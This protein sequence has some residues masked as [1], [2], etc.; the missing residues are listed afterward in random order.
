MKNGK[1]LLVKCPEG[2]PGKWYRGKYA[3][4]H[5]VEFWRREGRLPM[6]GYVVHHKNENP[7]DNSWDNLEEMLRATHTAQHQQE[8]PIRHGTHTGYRRG[9]RCN[10]CKAYHTAE[11]QQYRL[12]K[13][14]ENNMACSAN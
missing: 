10:E 4:A 5:I 7:H 13:K 6:P 11:I 14:Q 8:R 2:Y 12:R 1:Y 3:Y 9:C